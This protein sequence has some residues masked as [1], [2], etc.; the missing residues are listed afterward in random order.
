M[1]KLYDLEMK[2]IPYP[3]GLIPLD[4]FVSSLNKNRYSQEIQGRNGAIDYGFDYT[5]RD[6]ELSMWIKSYDTIGYRALRNEIYK[7]FDKYDKF[8]IEEINLPS[9]LLLVSVDDK[10]IPE[11]LQNNQRYSEV[12]INCKTLDQVFWVSKYTTIDLHNSKFDDSG[13]FA[14]ADNI[15]DE[16]TDY[17]FRTNAFS[18]FNASDVD[19]TPETMYLRIQLRDC[20]SNGNLTIRN[21]TTGETFVY[22]PK[23]DFARHYT[24]EGMTFASATLNVLRDTN[25][26]FISLAPGKNDFEILNCTFSAVTFDF[27]FY[28]K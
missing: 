21:K 27:R 23:I 26:Q 19:I 18:V 8:Y 17:I 7:Y 2:E 16:M 5:D 13:K 12:K 1:F 6:V 24:L 14:F 10:Y 3:K 9:R 25:L 20:I 22:F 15:N 11:R 28:Y 4:I